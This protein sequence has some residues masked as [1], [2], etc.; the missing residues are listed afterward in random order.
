MGNAFSIL[1][2]SVCFLLQTTVI[3]ATRRANQIAQNRYVG[4]WGSRG[5]EPAVG[6]LSGEALPRLGLLVLL[7]QAKRTI[8]SKIYLICIK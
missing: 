4:A 5:S 7:G 1:L 8:Y 2:M 6:F 3:L